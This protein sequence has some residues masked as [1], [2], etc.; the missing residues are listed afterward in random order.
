MTESLVEKIADAVLY[1]GSIL[2]PY[3]P[4]AVK[5]QQRWNFGALCPEPYAVAQ[6][7]TENSRMRTECLVESGS[8]TTVDV[9]VRFL[10]LVSREVAEL[11]EFT[12]PTT[13]CWHVS[14][15]VSHFRKQQSLE[16][17]G[18]ILQTWQEAIERE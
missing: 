9:K 8:L 7:G 12:L 18:K 3:R 13:V 16:V 4:S 10:H 2:Y 1:E 14:R 17:N 6:K 11:V 5:N 15:E